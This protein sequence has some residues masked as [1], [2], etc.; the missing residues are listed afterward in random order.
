MNDVFTVGIV[1][2]V[3]NGTADANHI[4]KGNQLPFFLILAQNLLQIRAIQKLHHKIVEVVCFGTRIVNLQNMLVPPLGHRP[5]LVD[6][7]LRVGGVV[8]QRIPHYFDSHWAVEAFIP[9]VKNLRHAPL[10]Q[11]AIHTVIAC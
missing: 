3:G 2:G 7:P 1:K 11:K 8:F 10:P 5:R 4:L 6:K 9:A